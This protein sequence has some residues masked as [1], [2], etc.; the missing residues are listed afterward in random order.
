[1]ESVLT[2][3]KANGIGLLA[4]LTNLQELENQSGKQHSRHTLC[5]GHTH[6]DGQ[7]KSHWN[8]LSGESLALCTELPDLWQQ[9][10]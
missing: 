5:D 2:S 9:N 8:S 1:M 6:S 3:T 7:K 10:F 4:A